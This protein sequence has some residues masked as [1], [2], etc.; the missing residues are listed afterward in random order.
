[1]KL[2]MRIYEMNNC[3][4]SDRFRC[5]THRLEGRKPPPDSLDSDLMAQNDDMSDK[6]T[7]KEY[8]G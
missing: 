6:M 8:A 2:Q 5:I 3:G 7:D 1:M 4:C